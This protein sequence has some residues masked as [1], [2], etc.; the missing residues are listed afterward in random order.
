MAEQYV[1]TSRLANVIQLVSLGRQTGILRAIRGHGASREM[2]Q[3]QFVEGQ[4]TAA[5]LGQLT[6]TTALNVLSN[7]GESYYTFDESELGTDEQMNPQ[8]AGAGQ[9]AYGVWPSGDVG[10]TG[11]PSA[12]QGGGGSYPGAP[13]GPAAGSW[14]PRATSSSLGA[15]PQVPPVSNPQMYNVG[16]APSIGGGQSGQ[17]G[18]GA[19]TYSNSGVNPVSGPRSTPPSHTSQASAVF[20]RRTM[21]SDAS[22]TLP[23]DRRE[24]MILLLVDGR[25]SV[26]DLGRLTRRSE[27]EVMAVL[28]NL[29]MLGLIE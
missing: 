10:W 12:G 11:R 5:M 23:L 27:A 28:G 6:G 1:A 24:R 8:D 18:G 7:W 14:P 29:K 2:G 16:S 4:P 13:A 9:P 3:I 26:A 21:R 19:A 17:L 20:P 22:D 15:M 25:R